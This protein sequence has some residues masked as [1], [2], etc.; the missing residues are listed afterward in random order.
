MPAAWEGAQVLCLE[1]GF[2]M[3]ACSS[4]SRSF[5]LHQCLTSWLWMYP[6][7]TKPMDTSRTSLC[8]LA[9]VQTGPPICIF[10]WVRPKSIHLVQVSVCMDSLRKCVTANQWALLVWTLLKAA[11]YRSADSTRQ[12][13]GK[14][15]CTDTTQDLML[16]ISPHV[17][18]FESLY[19]SSN[20][21]I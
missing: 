9:E 17:T 15:L 13:N 2:D 4:Q 1:W 16:E 6:W 21:T 12:G 14:I 10:R 3:A 7:P 20:A 18:L 11:G 5:S 19:I 8:E